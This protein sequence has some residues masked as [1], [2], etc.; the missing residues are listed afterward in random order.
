MD[1]AVFDQL[2]SPAGERA[3]RAATDLAPTPA[4]LLACTGRLRKHF[5]PDLAR[6]ALETV[7]LRAKAAVKFSRADRM[8]FTREAL[9]VSSSEAV[10]RHRAERFRRYETVGDFGCGIGGDAIGLTTAGVRVAA[11]DRDEL[12]TR[13]AAANLAAYDLADQAQFHVAD[14]LTD[15]LP[16]VPAAFA[17]PGRRADGKRFLSVAEYLPPPAEL[18]KRLPAGFPIAFKLAPG[19]AWGDLHGFDGEV[20]FISVGGELKECVLW[21]GELRTTGR[22][23]TVLGDHTKTVGGPGAQ[24]SAVFQEGDQGDQDFS[25]PPS[26]GGVGF[27]DA[28]QAH[29]LDATAALPPV[30][31]RPIGTFLYDPDPAVTRA[32]L[33]PVLAEQLGAEP[34]DAVVQS[35]TSDANTPTPF[36]TAYRVEEVVPVDVKKLTAALYARHVGRV[37]VV[38]RGSLADAETVLARW[39]HNGDGHRFVILTRELG[40]QVAVIADRV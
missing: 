23:A 33:V 20:E 8:F 40:R 13:M 16:D 31:P 2:L 27:P 3:L 14:L 25:H 21:L 19:V 1:L 35:L 5:A 6:A 24:K 17:D 39:K 29:T 22:R 34:I 26:R 18:L 9:E 11:V 4:T 30:T 28:C 32:G 10:S 36:A 7:L 15:P 38:N 37:T 12:R